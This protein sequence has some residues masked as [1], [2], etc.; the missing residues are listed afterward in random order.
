MSRGKVNGIAWKNNSEFA[1]CGND[2]IKFWTKNKA[3]Q[4]KINEKKSE[5]MFSIVNSGQIYITGGSSGGLYN[6]VGGSASKTNAHK[7]KVQT[8]AISNG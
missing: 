6:W 8:L 3:V 2:H 4:G 7:G 1:T 5:Q